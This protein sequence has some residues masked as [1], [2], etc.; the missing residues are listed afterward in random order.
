MAITF[1]RIRLARVFTQRCSYLFFALLILLTTL[2]F[3]HDSEQGRIVAN[4]INLS[5]LLAAVAAVGRTN[6]SFA[7][8]VL[9]ALPVVG[10]QVLGIVWAEPRYLMLSWS[11]GSCFYFT[12]L[13]LLLRYVL[14]PYVMTTDK[15]YG[16]AAAYLMLGIMWAYFYGI[17]QYF[18]PGAFAPAG[19][20]LTLFD[21]LYFSFTV[22]TTTGFGDIVPVLPVT[23]VLTILEQVVGILYVAILIARLSSMYPTSGA[24]NEHTGT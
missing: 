12:T 24:D 14:L 16:A 10:F 6:F 15:L 3:L 19:A 21:L 11:F 22:L 2:P 23:R 8:A 9:L 7:I 18:Y 13:V 4:L 1:A 20:P 5:I 17:I